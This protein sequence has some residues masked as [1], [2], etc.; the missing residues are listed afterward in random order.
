MEFVCYADWQQLPPSVERLFAEAE[1]E[2]L[3]FS[4]PWFENL[5][6]HGLEP[7]AVVQYAGVLEGDRLLALLPMALRDGR[8]AFPLKHLYTSL[9][10]LLITDEDRGSVLACLAEG[11]WHSPIQSLQLEPVAEEDENLQG[12]QQAMQAAGFSCERYFRFHNWF[13]RPQGQSYA[14]YLATRPSRVRNTLERKR[15][16]LEREHECR[17]QLYSDQNW[18]Q[19]LADYRAVYASSWKA[20]EQFEPFIQGLAV[21]LTQAGWLRLAV[22]YIDEQPAAAQ[23]WFVAQRKASIFKLAY[24]E[25]WKRYSPGSILTAHLMQQVIDTDEVE[26]IDFLT[27]NDAY[28]QEWMSARRD[29]WRLCFIKKSATPR[30]LSGM[31]K[32]LKE[33]VYNRFFR[34]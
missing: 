14:D 4:R 18:P 8:Y 22:L 24:D 20:A 29:R 21:R 30:P 17:I 6:E 2:S 16:K 33:R 13:H 32:R 9:Y 26:E 3:F 31:L 23:F 19:G 5:I 28:K 25:S 10:S 7:D 1:K 11:L 34:Q 15:R 27:G 12:L